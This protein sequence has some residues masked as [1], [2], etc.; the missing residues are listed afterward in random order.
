MMEKI[1]PPY[2]ADIDGLRAIAVLLV[3]GFHA[4]PNRISGGYVGVDVFFVIS[5][6]LITGLLL[7]ALEED[8]FRFSEFYLRRIRRIFPALVTVLIFCFA[9]GWFFLTPDEFKSLGKNIFGSAI[10]SS[11]FVLLGETGYFDG[12]SIV[13]KPL[14]HLWS[15]GVEEQFYIVW[16][17]LLWI[18]FSRKLSIAIVAGML[19]VVSFAWN[20]KDAGTPVGFYLPWARAWEL[21]IG[22]IIAAVASPSER[23]RLDRLS[24]PVRSIANWIIPAR[25]VATF[26][27]RD[28]QAFLGI[29]LVAAAVLI[30]NG[31]SQFPGWWA[32]LPTLGTALIIVADGAWFNRAIL[33]NRFAVWLGLMSYPLYLWHWPLLSFVNIISP[34]P[35]LWLRVMVVAAAMGLAWTT[36]RVIERPIRT[37]AFR[38]FKKWGLCTAMAAVGS[39]GLATFLWQGIPERISPAI[40]DIVT[41]RRT[42]EVLGELWRRHTCF[43]GRDEPTSSFKPECVEKDRRPLLLLWGDSTAAA[44]YP[45]LKQLQRSVDFGLAQYNMAA[46]PPSSSIT[47][48]ARPN[49]ADDNAFVLSVIADIRPDIVLLQAA[50]LAEVPGKDYL[51]PLADLIERL[52]QMKV[53]RIV[54]MGPPVEWEGRLTRAVYE[55]YAWHSLHAM[56][57]ARSSFRVSHARYRE[58]QRFRERALSLDAEYISTW[59]A[60]CNGEDCLTRVGDAAEDLITFDNY[61]LTVSG[62][63]YLV[64]LI[65]PC[66]FPDRYVQKP[67]QESQGADRSVICRR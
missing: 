58:A 29:G 19:L 45:G 26:P 23:V 61:H 48:Q 5:G 35:A 27:H 56:L 37:G 31:T 38:S 21:M 13:R 22:A 18:A 17:A 32:L 63:G 49:C 67:G 30:L 41:L 15:L 6:F 14:L 36:Y 57:P 64:Q 46:C 53:P 2:R 66:L 9:A 55:Y 1:T 7:H 34:R 3:I 50:W 4:A 54:I 42:P 24:G 62:S 25:A 47:V 11:N 59:D 33:S 39:V 60:L 40:R 8:R 20:I 44:L 65:A 12:L 43:L 10:F 52:H 28:V 16:P 51:S